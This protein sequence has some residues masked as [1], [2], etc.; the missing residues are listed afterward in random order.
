MERKKKKGENVTVHLFV[1][2]IFGL[3][4]RVAGCSYKARFPVTKFGRAPL[5]RGAE[6]GFSP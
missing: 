4:A 2:M 6:H 5:A 3:T 1:S